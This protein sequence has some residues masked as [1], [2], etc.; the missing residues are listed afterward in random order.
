MIK[1]VIIVSLGLGLISSSL[2]A[3]SPFSNTKVNVESSKNN[4]EQKEQAD[5][6]DEKSDKKTKAED[7]FANYYFPIT[8][9]IAQNNLRLRKWPWGEVSGKYNKDT[10]ITVLGVSGD[11]YEVIVLG[12]KGYMHRNFVSIP[13]HPAS[14]EKPDY[15]G[16][17]EKGG[18][19]PKEGEKSS[20]DESIES[21]KDQK[22]DEPVV[23]K[24]GGISAEE[25]KKQMAS[26]KTPTRDEIIKLAAA[27]KISADYVKILIG[28]TQRE[29]YFKDP[30]LHYGWASAMLNQKVTIKQMQGWDPKHKGESNY[31]S[32]TNI[33]K[34]YK[35]AKADVLKSVYLALK[36]RNT[37][38]IECN[39][40]YKKTPSSYKKIYSSSVYNCSIY[41]KK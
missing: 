6:K 23:V 18:Y 14:C 38:I 5:V 8:G 22:S 2:Y 20:S 39:G 28:T 10:K 30:Y 32:Q 33:D 37:K 3:A 26:M 12:V 1:K 27:S 36:Y 21:G 40:M 35:A 24:K 17:T 4:E 11:F 19:I 13:D 7:E 31:Y 25:F 29:G 9:T 15:P 16:N 34:G 41:E